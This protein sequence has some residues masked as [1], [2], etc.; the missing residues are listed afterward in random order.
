MTF[1]AFAGIPD[2]AGDAISVVLLVLMMGLLGLALRGLD[3]V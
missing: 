1:L 2:S 3:R